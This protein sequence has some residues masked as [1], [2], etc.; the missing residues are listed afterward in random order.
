MLI[1]DHRKVS[2][3]IVSSPKIPFE[4]ITIGLFLGKV[5]SL[6]GGPWFLR[7]SAMLSLIMFSSVISLYS[8]NASVAS[9]LF[10]ASSYLAFSFSY[11]TFSFSS[12]IICS[13]FKA[14]SSSGSIPTPQALFVM[15]SLLKV[16]SSKLRFLGRF[17]A[18]NSY[19][20]RISSNETRGAYYCWLFFS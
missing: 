4:R 9:F 8:R 3:L 6:R 15:K 14:S 12:I 20:F 5:F 16:R 17:L 7:L 10:W 19:C 13:K 18:F 11:P 1:S 2:L